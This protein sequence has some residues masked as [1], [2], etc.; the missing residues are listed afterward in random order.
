MHEDNFT[1]ACLI[2]D[3]DYPDAGD[4]RM[5]ATDAGL[6]GLP[7]PGDKAGAT[8]FHLQEIQGSRIRPENYRNRLHS[9]RRFLTPERRL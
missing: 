9:V 1:P 2:D 7:S 8:I 4:I 5:M 3:Y 6:K